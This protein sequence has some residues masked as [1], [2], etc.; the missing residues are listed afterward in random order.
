MAL[1]ALDWTIGSIAFGAWTQS[2]GF[3]KRGH[4]RIMAWTVF[5]FG[6]IALAA[7]R[8]SGDSFA[9]ATI[10][11]AAGAAIYLVSQY[12]ESDTSPVV[13]GALATV[14]GAA[15]I[16][17]AGRDLGGWPDV[18][19]SLHLIA[20]AA[21]LGGVTNGMLLGHWYLNQ[22]GLK[23][24]ALARLSTV[25]SISTT[26]AATIGAISAPRLLDAT[27]D[28]AVLG[29]PG[30]GLS[31]GP[32]FFG[33]WAALVVATGAVIWM[34]RRCVSIRSIQSATGL[35]YVALLTG[36]VTQFLVCYLIVRSA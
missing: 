12:L 36:G 26:I 1:V 29:L 30:F 5:G 16:W 35:Y 13:A 15:A 7:G 3:I 6:V 14:A 9:F 34:A 23:P 21:L 11:A 8:A 33:I 31:F 24:E 22:P 27:T 17:I 19:G 25:A 32:A 18:L 4:F 10:A 20:G 2:W 28:G